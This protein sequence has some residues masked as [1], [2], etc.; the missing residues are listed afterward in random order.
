MALFTKKNAPNPQFLVYSEENGW[1][2]R[3]GAATQEEA[4]RKLAAMIELYKNQN[5][6]IYRKVTP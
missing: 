5:Y 3:K 4:E 2:G 1:A 6:K